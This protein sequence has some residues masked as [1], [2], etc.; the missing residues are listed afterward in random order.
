MDSVSTPSS[1]TATNPVFRSGAVAKMATM[2][3]STLR[4]WEQ[5]YE[6]V[7]PASSPSGHRMYSAADVE[8]V[9]LLRELTQKGHAIG[10]LAGLDTPRLQEVARL[11]A[12]APAAQRATRTAAAAS[13]RVVV[14]GQGLAARLQR[15]ALGRHLERPLHV[16]AV[17]DSLF[18]AA[19]SAAERKA[20][21]LVWLSPG[22][23]PEVSADLQ[24]AQGAWQ[25]RLTAIAY[26]FASAAAC[27]AWTERGVEVVR[28]PA[29]D[30]A[31]GT[32]L[33]SLEASL[34]ADNPGP[35]TAP[36][37]PLV[38]EAPGEPV[39][40][41]RFDDA[42]L[43]AMAAISPSLACECPRHVAEL[44]MQLASFEAYSAECMNRDRA[45]ARLHVYLHQVAGRARAMFETAL[46]RVA[47]HEGLPLR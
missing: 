37:S 25:V 20:D 33:A 8:R 7:R 38:T 36:P 41:R 45:D 5:R 1:T 29:D 2:P 43:T 23:H 18:E 47:Q 32:W 17:F 19:S 27:Q 24:A 39:A 15:P 21:V 34:R 11:A 26:R 12:T 44:L 16:L 9:L 3:V 13:L 35:E 31:L 22:L 40:P 4:I 42:A 30:E 10:T 28:E 6:A 46:E 14:I